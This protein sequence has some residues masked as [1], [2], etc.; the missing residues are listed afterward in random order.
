MSETLQGDENAKNILDLE[1]IPRRCVE[2][3]SQLDDPTKVGDVIAQYELLSSR[4]KGIPARQQFSPVGL[5]ASRAL[6]S[7][8]EAIEKKSPSPVGQT[9][10]P[11]QI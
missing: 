8:E 5:E 9:P 2:L 10:T 6:V 1:A 11:E 7:L 4:F 3:T